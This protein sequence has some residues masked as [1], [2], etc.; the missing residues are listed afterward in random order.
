MASPHFFAR[1]RLP[2][3]AAKS[4]AWPRVRWNRVQDVFRRIGAVMSATPA[5]QQQFVITRDIDASAQ[6]VFDAIVSTEG[7]LAWVIG[8]RA[9]RWQHAR[10]A[11]APGIGSLRILELP[12]SVVQERIVHWQAGRQLNYQL[13]PPSPLQKLVTRY[14][15]VNEVIATGPASCRL[16]WA[17][18]YDTPGLQALIAPGFRL[19][20]RALIGQMATRLARFAES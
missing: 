19:A 11:D 17:I 20:M 15:G 3:T 13:Q 1:L 4:A 9:A 5:A 2:A 14:E 10:G 8:C 6:Q 16:S 18:H 12:G 7:M